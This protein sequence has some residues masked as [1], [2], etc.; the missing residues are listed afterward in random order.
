MANWDMDADSS[1]DAM[2]LRSAASRSIRNGS[3][4]LPL[5]LLAV[6][7]LASAWPVPARAATEGQDTAAAASA[8][9]V[10]RHRKGASIDDRV[11]FLSKALGLD[12]KQQS[13]LRKVLEAQREEIGKV[14]A[15]EEAP[16]AYRIKATETISEQTA[17]RIRA[18]LNDEQKKKYNAPRQRPAP[19]ESA[20]PDVE[21]WMD[22]GKLK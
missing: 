14:W 6:L 17:D 19:G 1:I 20:R 21:A 9:Q 2:S 3:V 16:A 13:E 11:R 5:A 18:L 10:P 4:L 12:A 7:V 15:D 22:A 8:R